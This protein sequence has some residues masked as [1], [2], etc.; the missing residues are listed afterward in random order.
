[1]AQV[2]NLRD[3]IFEGSS[4]STLIDSSYRVSTGLLGQAAGPAGSGPMGH[5]LSLPAFANPG[6]LA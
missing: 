6:R 2:Q 1:M 3:L 4:H 5:A